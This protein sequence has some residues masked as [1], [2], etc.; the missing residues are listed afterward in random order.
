MTKVGV[1][2]GSFNPIHMAHLALAEEAREALNLARVIFVPARMPPHK[3]RM[4]LA[5]ARDRL[6]MARLAAAGNPAFEVSD[7][8]LRRRG[9]SYTIDTI[10]ALRRRLGSD[11][12]IYFLIG[13][14][15]VSELPTW[16]EIGALS[17]LCRFTPLSRPGAARP[18][19]RSL[20]AVV[21]REEARAILARA[22]AMPRL[23]ISASD[24][25]A[26][27]VAGRSV[28]YLIPDAVAAYIRKRG[29]YRAR[30]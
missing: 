24:I 29:L 1:F 18:A 16:R 7:I 3:A 27:L 19:L 20:A 8:E 10:R 22:V 5:A 12:E 15:T 11:V 30:P 13:Q 17:R 4:G 14:D 6:E 21:G 25:R 23:E 2:G 28:R 9:P 26:R